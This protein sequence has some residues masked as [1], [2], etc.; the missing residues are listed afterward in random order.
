MRLIDA[1]GH[2]CWACKHH[3]TGKCDTWCD[4]SE[5]FE[6]REDIKNANTAYDVEAVVKELEEAKK[7]ISNITTLGDCFKVGYRKG[8]NEAIEIVKGGVK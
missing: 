3:T 1:D 2:E 8:I 5:A 7:D 6:L 4:A